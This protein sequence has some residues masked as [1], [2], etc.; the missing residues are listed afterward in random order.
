[1]TCSTSIITVSAAQDRL[2]IGIVGCG[3][4]VN[5]AALPTYRKHN[6]N[7]VDATTFATRRLNARPGSL[8]SERLPELD[9]LLATQD[10]NR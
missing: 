6:L 3:G 4:I 8:T 7:V 1:M 5:Y 10:R 2:R 9:D